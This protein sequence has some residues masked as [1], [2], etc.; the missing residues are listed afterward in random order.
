[1]R[2]VLF[3]TQGQIG[4]CFL[5]EKRLLITELIDNVFNHA[6][7]ETLAAVLGQYYPNKHRLEVAIVDMSRGIRTSLQEGHPTES[8]QQ[9][10]DLAIQRGITR[11]KDAG[12]GN[13]LAGTHAIV[14]KNGG[15]LRLWSGDAQ[16]HIS[17]GN[18]KGYYNIPAMQGTG[19]LIKLFTHNPVNLSNTFI[20]GADW[21][22]IDVLREAIEEDGSLKVKDEVLN[23]STRKAASL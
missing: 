10:L 3:D 4:L 8:D 16:Y 2:S 15:S 11:N 18:V 5:P 21:S 13:G 14:L 23:S 12:Q 22:Y 9:A 1:M 19:V 17:K 6:N 20:G 7:I